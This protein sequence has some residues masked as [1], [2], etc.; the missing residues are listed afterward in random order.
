M[1]DKDYLN[2]D[3]SGYSK[4]DASAIKNLD[5]TFKILKQEENGVPIKEIMARIQKEDD[6]TEWEKAIYEKSGN[7]RWQS[8]LAFYSVDCVKA[9]FLKKNKGVW[10]ATEEGEKAHNKGPIKFLELSG[11]GYSA[12]INKKNAQKKVKA[13]DDNVLD[14]DTEQ[15]QKATLESLEASAIE[16][17]R[18]YITSV[19][20]Y[21]F[22]DMVAALLR[23]MGYHTPF[24]S[25]KGRDGGIDIVAYQDPLGAKEPR[26]KVQ[27]KHRP[28]YSVSV[29]EIRSLTGLLN[30]TGDIGLFITSGRFTNEAERYSRDSQV[31]VKLMDFTEFVS[32]WQEYY[33]KLTDEDKNRLPLQPIYFLGS[34][35]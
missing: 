8:L 3:L 23:A 18:N 1:S 11:E 7:V 15:E 5:K 32:L 29:D 27:V 9:G 21:E 35:D 13:E 26:I 22:Q 24:I 31:H 14:S 17:I 10:Y 25:P 33:M 6:L 30:R 4:S 2:L 34:N 20:P 16:G 28:D 12:W 19:N